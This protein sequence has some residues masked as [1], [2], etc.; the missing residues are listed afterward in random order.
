MAQII[1][2][3]ASVANTNNNCIEENERKFLNNNNLTTYSVR[4]KS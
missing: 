3:G 2:N 1:A 4:I